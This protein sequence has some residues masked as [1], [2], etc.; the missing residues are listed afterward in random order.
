MK[1]DRRTFIKTT[2]LASATLLPVVNTLAQT[3]GKKEDEI[4]TLLASSF[5]SNL[6][7]HII[8][9]N[10]LNLHFYF[11]NVKKDGSS[12][13]PSSADTSLKSFMIVRLP[14]MHVS[15]K[16]YWKDDWNDAT[17]PEKRFPNATLSGY[18]YLAFQLWPNEK[19]SRGASIPKKLQ[20]TLEKVLNW[21]NERI[22]D[23]ITLVEWF[24]L[25][26][27]IPEGKRKLT[28]EKYIDSTGETINC[29]TF[30]K[31]KTINISDSKE[32]EGVSVREDFEPKSEI[33]KKYKYIVNKF[34]YQKDDPKNSPRNFIPI[35]FLEVP[36]GLCIIPIIRNQADDLA[37]VEDKIKKQFWKNELVNQ[38]KVNSVY[39]KYEVWN[40]TLFYKSEIQP[41][42]TDTEK[43]FKF[44]TTSFRVVGIL[45]T[46]ADGE[47]NFC[48]TNPLECQADCEQQKTNNFLPSLLD[49][50]ELA[51]LTQYA[52]EE[53]NEANNFT[54]PDFDIK[55]VNGFFFTGLGIITHLKYYNLDKCPTGIDLIEY[56]HIIN[57]GRDI[58]IRVARLGYNSKTGQRYKHIIEGRKKI[59]S[60]IEDENGTLIYIFPEGATS[61]I[62]LKQY[63]ECIDKHIVYTD[64]ASDTNWSKKFIPITTAPA[65]S[66]L[67]PANSNK[68][69]YK[70]N[71]FKELTT[72]E[73]KRIPIR[74]LYQ[75]EK[76]KPAFVQPQDICIIQ[77]LDWFWPTIESATETNQPEKEIPVAKYMQ[78]EYEAIDWEDKTIRASTPFMFIRASYF[79]KDVKN[80]FAY[81]NYFSGD[82]KTDFNLIERRKTYFNNQKIAFT[83]S[84]DKDNVEKIAELKAKKDDS[85]IKDISKREKELNDKN[86]SRSK[87]NI[88]ETEFIEHYFI[89]KDKAS[90]ED[91]KIVKTKYV[92]FPQ[93]LRAKVYIDHIRELTLQKIPSI[94]EYQKDYIEHEFEDFDDTKKYANAAKVILANTDAFINGKEELVNNKY[95]E[96]KNA[97]QEAKD[98]LG[99]LAVPDIIPDSISLKKFGVTLPKDLND[100]IA[101]GK[102]V[103]SNASDT[104]GKIVSFNPRELLRGKLSDVCGLDLTAI[105]DELLPVDEK[106]AQGNIQNHT[107]LF[108][109]NKILNK[110]EGEIL[111][112]P[113]YNDI[114]NGIEIEDPIEND[115]GTHDKLSPDALIKK[116][117]GKIQALRNT[118]EGERL[119]L[120]SKIK[121]LSNKI[122]NAD[123]LDH[124]VKNLFEKYR[125]QAFEII[126][127]DIPLNNINELLT[128]INNG[129]TIIQNA[130]DFF[131][132][133][134]S[135]LKEESKNKVDDITNVLK[136]I[137]EE[138]NT[139]SAELN[140]PIYVGLLNKIKEVFIDVNNNTFTK[141]NVTFNN[142]IEK[143]Y[144]DFIGTTGDYQ[145]FV[146]NRFDNFWANCTESQFPKILN[147]DVAINIKTYEFEIF[148]NSHSQIR[149]TKIDD[150]N[151]TGLLQIQRKISDFSLLI[152]KNINGNLFQKTVV[153]ELQKNYINQYNAN[154]NSY[155]SALQGYNDLFLG[156]ISNKIKNWSNEID[157]T[158]HE[159]IKQ[160]LTAKTQDSVL[161][162]KSLIVRLNPYIDFL[163]KLDPYFYYTEQLRLGKDIDDV[164]SKFFGSLINVYGNAEILNDLKCNCGDPDKPETWVF[165]SILCEIKCCIESYNSSILKLLQFLADPRN[166]LTHD[167][168]SQY[169]QE[170]NKLVIGRLASVSSRA[171]NSLRNTDEY[172]QAAAI[173]NEIDNIKDQIKNAEGT[174]KNYLLQYKN[175]L[176]QQATD[177]AKQLDQKVKEYIEKQENKLIDAVGADNILAIQ[178]N[179]NEAKNIY[180]LLTSIKQQ[181][182]TYNWSTDKFRDVNLGIVSFKKFSNP[183]TTLKVDVKATTYFTSGKFPPAIEKVVTY[184][185]NRFTNFGISFFNSLTVNFNEISFIA[186]SDHS[187]HFDVKIKDVK[188][189]GA[190]SFVQA[191]ESWLQTMGK[192]LILQLHGDHVALGYSL[193]I[194]AIKTPGFNIFNLSLNFD[195]RVYFDKRPLRFGFSLARPDSKFGIAVGIYAGFGFFG[196][197]ADPKKGIVEIDCALEAGAWAGI[198]FGPFSGEVKLAFGFRYT[199]NEFGVRLEGYIVAEGRLSFWV[200]EVA[201]RIYLGIVSQNSYVEGVCTVTYSVKI[202]FIK[203]SFSGSFHKKIAG[204]NS[205]NSNAS[206]NEIAQKHEQ[207]ETVYYNNQL[208]KTLNGGDIKT[209]SDR[210]I[211]F[212]KTKVFQNIVDDLLNKNVNEEEQV[213]YAVE[214]KE[215]EDFIS[216][217]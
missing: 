67:T 56:E 192:G 189:D 168:L 145:T 123:E 107:P 114:I 180:H 47:K 186:G 174:L 128:Q 196:I 122:P 54:A 61:F 69:D 120:N 109:I 170:S 207:L 111:K 2:S 110:I 104:L 113:V 148:N 205:N 172:K 45:L 16:G 176:Q 95:G 35:T 8:D 103:I 72:I 210:E 92:V 23:L 81:Q 13:V 193:A 136:Q 90:F 30:K 33:Y 164:K 68:P 12:L 43:K 94:I 1:Q 198:S 55:E 66:V 204:A 93:V 38:F 184:S 37:K 169:V 157:E 46:K 215:W 98:K 177:Y 108:E 149:F 24:K 117:D 138:K 87:V 51:Y 42:G 39:R 64:E 3:L 28:F 58:F 32:F 135:L 155:V 171:M 188:F 22:F 82:F 175:I 125:T 115:D 214:L 83:K 26:E 191:F 129:K 141:I 143:L 137:N 14:Q 154:L 156:D 146:K 159:A 163:R 31:R 131:D 84:L 187:T 99:N 211:S 213:I 200:I 60:V 153:N 9:N 53:R 160:N 144:Q 165:E 86:A 97:L 116:Y 203:K 132:T 124:L 20:L 75:P 183:D 41:A 91:G 79:E 140:K 126:K 10:L 118:I 162:I 36:Q 161:K 63:C 212:V 88:L 17:H 105:L 150:L 121:E 21:N 190:L 106:D 65:D 40:N 85:F 139:I 134:M 216:V 179:I 78:C 151:K 89:I 201:A 217:F 202:G 44:E 59:E 48:V 74:C 167:Y 34:L 62:E 101:K 100:S 142:S 5:N 6:E 76:D 194:P 112:S 29:D 206:G 19:D 152:I 18:S 57:Q 119:K 73:K 130:V 80:T 133:E 27:G 182:L 49:K 181:D 178:A 4:S 96:I 195:L 77:C 25:N 70:R 71:V 50:R 102:T 173:L 158:L 147:N 7:F 11:I 209:L 52:K 166:P 15:E 197:V 199:K 208:I 185:E 127:E